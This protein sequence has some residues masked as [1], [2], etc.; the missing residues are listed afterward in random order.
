MRQ[1]ISW[2]AASTVLFACAVCSRSP[3]AA[4]GQQVT[5][6]VH[7]FATEAEQ[8]LTTYSGVREPLERVIRDHATWRDMWAAIWGSMVPER[9]L[10]EVDFTRDMVVVVALGERRTGGYNV[11]VSSAWETE[12]RVTVEARTR[13]P[14]TACFVTQ[15]FTY[16]L[17]AVRV[18]RRDGPVTFTNRVETYDCR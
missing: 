15:A 9:P 1:L 5:L 17:D 6:P 16:P 10:P 18:P 14:G 7:R 3:V 4:S 11:L 8:G 2:A 12:G 13:M